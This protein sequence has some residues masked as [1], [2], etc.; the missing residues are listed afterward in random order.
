V[1]HRLLTVLG[2][3]AVVAASLPILS[4]VPVTLF[5][6]GEVQS[7]RID[8]T[9]PEGT[10]AASMF[11]EVQT[12]ETILGR[13]AAAG[14]VESYQVTLGA[15][16]ESDTGIITGEAGFDVAGFFITVSDDLPPDFP[17][18][19]RA[20]LPKTKMLKCCC[21]LTPADLLSPIRKWPSP[22][23]ILPR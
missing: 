18:E 2:C 9:M 12:V 14:Y 7:L 17:S 21:S 8:I 20:S 5:S 19:L 15:T 13:H 22:A 11:R 6:T 3:I 23:P 4:I 1:R 10:D 16:T